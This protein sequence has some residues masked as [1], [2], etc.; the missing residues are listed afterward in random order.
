MNAR[1]VAARLSNGGIVKRSGSGWMVCCP[2]HPDDSPSLSIA[3]GEKAVVMHCHAGCR[4]DDVLAASGL[5]WSELSDVEPEPVSPNGEVAYDYI[6]ET[7]HLRYQVVRRPG[8]KFLQRRPGPDGEW[9]WNLRGV[10][11][12][13]YRLPDVMRAVKNGDP[14]WIT[15]GEKDADYVWATGTCAT[16]L[17]GGAGKWQDSYSEALEG[18]DVTIWA[19]RDEPGWRHAHAVRESLLGHNVAS[20]RIVESAHGKDAA[21]HLS[22]GLT[23]DDVLVTVPSEEAEAPALFLRADEFLAQ[24]REVK[25]WAIPGLMR[26][27]GERLI[28]TG[29]E[30]YGKS[31]LLK[32]I[33]V[34]TAVGLHP[35]SLAPN[36]SPKRVVFVDCENPCED[37]LE[38][39]DRLRN[40][41]RREG[42]WNDP[43]LFIECH[44]PLN[45]G[46]IPDAAWLAERARAHQP[47]L[48]VIGPLYNLMNGD[49]SKEVEVAR[50][51]RVLGMVQNEVDCALVMEHHVPHAN[52]GD[53]RPIRPIGSTILQR[54]SSF[55]FGLLPT[56]ID[57][58]TKPFQ[59]KAW[60][61]SRRR[62]RTW[63]D[64]IRQL[65]TG[66]GGWYWGEC[67]P[68][69]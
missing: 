27:G 55:G 40:A 63:P 50:M 12:V 7:G 62:G 3:D 4:P 22:H 14:V 49:S 39:F 48:L 30:G 58:S 28:L 1:D 54:W 43:D 68:V 15:E 52:G 37:L 9:V 42:V 24:S 38:D 67:A 47:D 33:A 57:D 32:Q 36:G 26:R 13:L 56:D 41:A 31:A 16:T 25:P 6:D 61:G 60:R 29:Y 64:A 46:D 11:R 18:A 44:P 21:D 53:E 20:V 34:C 17:P 66:G 51:L 5:D 19:D 35:F 8:K 45:L 65:S 59:F 23:L 10:D 2:A 69:E